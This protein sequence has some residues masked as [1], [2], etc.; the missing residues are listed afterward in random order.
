MS[1]NDNPCN[2]NSVNTAGNPFISIN[3]ALMKARAAKTGKSTVETEVIH[4]HNPGD[5]SILQPG[6]NNDDTCN[7]TAVT[8]ASHLLQ[9]NN[10]DSNN[11]N[12]S[13]DDKT[14][15]TSNSTTKNPTP[16]QDILQQ[17]EFVEVQPRYDEN[18]GREGVEKGEGLKGH[19]WPSIVGAGDGFNDQDWPLIDKICVYLYGYVAP[20]KS[21]PELIKNVYI[22][23]Y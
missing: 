9:L 6:Y 2:T 18:F 16:T 11:N 15:V 14:E 7:Q 12:I 3:Q 17:D 19:Q 20:V 13:D 8:L 10:Q 1:S 21:L 22:E 23:T 5:N 4:L